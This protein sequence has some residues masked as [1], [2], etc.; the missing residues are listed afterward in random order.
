LLLSM[1]S[2][3]ISHDGGGKTTSGLC[4]HD[5]IELVNVFSRASAV[6]LAIGSPLFAGCC[7]ESIRYERRW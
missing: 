2:L 1:R 6:T 3:S 4:C 7:D 5:L